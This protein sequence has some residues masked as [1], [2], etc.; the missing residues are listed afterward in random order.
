MRQECDH[1]VGWSS[2]REVDKKRVIALENL[3][4]ERERLKK[5]VGIILSPGLIYGKS[6]C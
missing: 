6:Y 3:K 4:V 2:T 1:L 5:K